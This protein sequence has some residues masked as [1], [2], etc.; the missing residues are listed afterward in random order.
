MTVRLKPDTTGMRRSAESNWSVRRRD[1]A[2]AH[3]L[4]RRRDRGAFFELRVSLEDLLPQ[5]LLRGRIDNRPQQRKDPPLTVHRVAPR[6]ERDVTAVAAALLPHRKANQL[7]AL[8]R[9]VAE[10]HLRFRQFARRISPFVR[11]DLDRHRAL[12][13]EPLAL[14][15]LSTDA[16]SLIK[17]DA[18]GEEIDARPQVIVAKAIGIERTA[19]WYYAPR[20]TAPSD[21]RG[22][23]SV[24]EEQHLRHG[25]FVGMRDGEQR[26]T[27]ADRG[28]AARGAAVQLQLRRAAAAAA[29]ADSPQPPPPAGPPQAP[30]PHPFSRSPPSGA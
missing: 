23:A 1:P 18:G 27:A 12:L 14:K 10:V 20:T 19:A 7:Q 24:A 6:R 15:R 25:Q 13:R 21:N 26:R 8:E 22:C 11:Q 9:A 5:L 16:R 4:R 2:S 3:A 29:L 17:V 28:E 30:P